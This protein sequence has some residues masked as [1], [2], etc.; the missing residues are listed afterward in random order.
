MATI[1]TKTSST[2]KA[3]YHVHINA[4]CPPT[5]PVSAFAPSI[6]VL[7]PPTVVCP[8]Y[9]TVKLP[10]TPLSDSFTA[11]APLLSTPGHVLTDDARRHGGDHRSS[12]RAATGV[13]PRCAR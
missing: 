9:T 11:H 13:F 3:S 7:L 5:S 2:G 1:R 8:Y 6:A 10:F 4:F 12:Q